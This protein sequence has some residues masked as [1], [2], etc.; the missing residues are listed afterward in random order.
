MEKSL[1]HQQDSKLLPHNLVFNATDYLAK[2]DP[3]KILIET[4]IIGIDESVFKYILKYVYVL[5]PLL[6]LT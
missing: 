1:L 4:T 5:I 6:A 3:D 2:V